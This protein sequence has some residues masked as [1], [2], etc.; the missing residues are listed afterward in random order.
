MAENGF[1]SGLSKANAR[2]ALRAADDVGFAQWR[3][4][5]VRDGFEAPIEIIDRYQELL[6]EETAAAGEAPQGA[7]DPASTEDADAAKAAADAG[8][9]TKVE[10]AG[11]TE[12]P[13]SGEALTGDAA[14]TGEGGVKE[15]PA[16]DDLPADN[17]DWTHKRLDQFASDNGLEVTKTLSKP[18]KVAAILAAL[19][20]KE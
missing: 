12:A 4:R 2:R 19:N 13:V 1:I 15:A 5:A 14:V 10:G 17:D 16:S 8:A 11:T 3:V 6:E 7:P 18:D 20:E 9:G